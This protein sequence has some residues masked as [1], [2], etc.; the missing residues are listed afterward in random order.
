MYTL[1]DVKFVVEATVTMELLV[2]N[3]DDG[4]RGFRKVPENLLELIE[5]LHPYECVEHHCV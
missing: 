1:E 4:L 2:S 5:D 3:K